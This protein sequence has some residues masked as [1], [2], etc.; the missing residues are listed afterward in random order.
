MNIH[1]T[2]PDCPGNHSLAALSRVA[3]AMAETFE[4]TEVLERG[5]EALIEATGAHCGEAYQIGPDG[6]SLKVLRGCK[7][8]CPFKQ[9]LEAFIGAGPGW[10]RWIGT[11]RPQPPKPTAG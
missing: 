6:P 7:E 4:P 9:R 3:A 5:I 8:F 2:L 1:D 10:C 11:F